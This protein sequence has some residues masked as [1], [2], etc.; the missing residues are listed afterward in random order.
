[1]NANF[2]RFLLHCVWYSDT[3][4]SFPVPPLSSRQNFYAFFWYVSSSKNFQTLYIQ[5]NSLLISIRQLFDYLMSVWNYVKNLD[6]GVWEKIRVQNSFK[7]LKR[8]RLFIIFTWFFQLF[9]S[10]SKQLWNLF[11]FDFLNLD[12][13]GRLF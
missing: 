9:L 7:G 2:Q 10:F 6:Q 5:R 13:V 11:L 12:C 3:L 8:Y 1:M 4:N